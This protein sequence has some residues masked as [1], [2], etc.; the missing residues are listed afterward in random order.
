MLPVRHRRLAL[1]ALAFLA[2]AVIILGC[3]QRGP[4]AL[5]APALAA[6][7]GASESHR[8]EIDVPDGAPEAPALTAA[9][10]VLMDVSS[11]RVLYAKN[12]HVQR[13]PAS[14]TKVMTALLALEMGRP[15][16]QVRVSEAAAAAGG[17]SIWLE[18]GETQTLADLIYGLML[19]SGNDCAEAIAEHVA[20]SVDDFV[21]LMNR[22]AADLGA[23]DTHFRNPH[24]L[25]ASGHVSTAAD[26]ALVSRQALLRPDFAR[27]VA[28]RR[29][30]IPW[31][32]QPWDR[33]VYNENR[34]LWLYP[35]ADGVK[36]GW[37]NEAGRCLVASAT[38]GGWQLVAVLLDA[39][40]MWTD[41]T[42]LLDWGF[43]SF[44]SMVLY[45][46]G[47]VVTRA[48]VAGAAERWVPLAAGEAVKV[49]V[50]PGE[51]DRVS[52][53]VDPPDYVRS[54]LAKGTEV[55]T[56]RLVVDGVPFCPVPLLAA[57]SV[58]PG[59]LIGRFIEDLW[60]L[61]LGTLRRLLG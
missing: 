59:G 21:L 11:G 4:G 49:A 29:H 14:L 15:E 20:G 32:G 35:G 41:A 2:A 42:Q 40:E 8:A 60:V 57:E 34:L 27:I 28:T 24:G 3:P 53:D 33:A 54:P 1:R 44:R 43:D 16:E 23:V 31:L 12:A 47:D 61:L 22:R 10:A 38:R 19:R 6:E 36:T 17:S 5:P 25:P 13:P 52:L 51:E 58:P 39:P 26:L 55:G 9:S 56:V 37:T 48:R 45:A 50:L 46:K 18:A 30:V 7:P